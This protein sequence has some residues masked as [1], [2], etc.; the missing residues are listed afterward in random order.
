MRTIAL[1]AASAAAYTEISSVERSFMSYIVEQGKTYGTK[2]EYEFRFEQFQE[3]HNAI[4]ELNSMNG[5]ATYGHNQFSDLTSEEKKRFLGYKGPETLPENLE[6]TMPTASSVDWRSKGAVNPVKNQ[7][8]CGS[9]WAFSAT[10]AIEGHHAIA[11]GNL[12]SLAEQQIVDCDSSCA[13]CNGG[14]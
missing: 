10:C 14:W 13:G 8:Q 6:F 1:L 12:I 5:S 2:E 7:G 9:C 4:A 3:A 11:T